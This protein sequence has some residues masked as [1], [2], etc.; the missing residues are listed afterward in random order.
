M[1]DAEGIEP[2]TCRLREHHVKQ[3][4]RLARNGW[5]AKEAQSSRWERSG[6]LMWG[7]VG[8]ALYRIPAFWKVSRTESILTLPPLSS[9]PPLASAAA[10][11][12]PPLRTSSAHVSRPSTPGARSVA[13][14]SSSLRFAVIG[15][16]SSCGRSNG[17]NPPL[18]QLRGHDDV[19]FL[20]CSSRQ[21]PSS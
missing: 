4:Q 7:F 21:R 11:S 5:H 2:S 10:G 20:A 17:G 8:V 19:D 9:R 6:S 16:V 15:A 1:V 14:S 13:R 3:F 12:S 18:L